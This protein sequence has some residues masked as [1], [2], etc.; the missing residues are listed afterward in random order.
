MHSILAYGINIKLN[1]DF[2]IFI[3]NLNRRLKGDVR[4][5]F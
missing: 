5:M 1:K 3:D 4:L 2:K